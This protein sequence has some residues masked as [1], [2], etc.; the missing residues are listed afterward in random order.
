MG[1]EPERI[2]VDIDLHVLKSNGSEAMR[3]SLWIDED[4]VVKQMNQSEEATVEAVYARENA[5]WPQNPVDFCQESVL[6][7]RR[8]DVVEHREANGSIKGSIFQ[9]HR[10]GI[11]ANNLYILVPYATPETPGQSAVDLNAC[12][13]LHGF[14]QDFRRG[15]VSGADL[16]NVGAD[17]QTFEGPGQGIA[18]NGHLPFRR[19]AKQ[20][21]KK[22]HLRA[23]GCPGTLRLLLSGSNL[24]STK[25]K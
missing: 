1:A 20:A 14:L 6:Q 17:I 7:L 9:R 15:A 12:E 8:C 16:E 22:V 19:R 10:S 5:V 23:S 11:P 25:P 21:M 2:R 18:L 4:Q 13:L 3:K 24:R